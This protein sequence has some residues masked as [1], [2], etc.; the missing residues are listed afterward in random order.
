MTTDYLPY[1]YL[2]IVVV[3]N[4]RSSALICCVLFLANIMCQ[5]F[6]LWSLIRVADMFFCL[7]IFASGTDFYEHSPYLGQWNA[8]FSHAFWG[9]ARVH[10]M[11]FFHVASIAKPIECPSPNL[12]GSH[13]KDYVNNLGIHNDIKK[14]RIFGVF[15]IDTTHRIH[16]RA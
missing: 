16:K 15:L 12:S 4:V 14:R 13:W 7:L 5:S 1:L 8:V 11:P 9:Q 3:C 6:L 10:R 2:F